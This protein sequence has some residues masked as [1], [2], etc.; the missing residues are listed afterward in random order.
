MLVANIDEV[1]RKIVHSSKGGQESPIP[2]MG[3]ESKA[4][5]GQQTKTDFCQFVCEL[6]LH[7][8]LSKEKAT[9]ILKHA[10]RDATFKGKESFVQRWLTFTTRKPYGIMQSSFWV[11]QSILY[12]W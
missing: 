8:K 11:S 10:W 4:S 2:S 3:Q 5:N 1:I 7:R 12:I 9:H 6:L